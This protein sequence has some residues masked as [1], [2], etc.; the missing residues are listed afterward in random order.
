MP[1]I[2]VTLKNVRGGNSPINLFNYFDDG[3]RKRLPKLL[4]EEF[5]RVIIENID[6]NKFNFTLAPAWLAEKAR[7]GADSRPFIMF[8]YYKK[9]ITIVTEH[10]HLAVGFGKMV[11]HPRAGVRMVDLALKLEFGDPAKG[12]P[13]RPLWR[14]SAED[15]FKNYRGKIKQ[16]AIEAINDTSHAP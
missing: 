8:G 6:S 5:Y 13:A 2:K 16:L 9:A 12:L 14:R 10:G 3:I 11:K 1:E 15:F 4:A 7:L